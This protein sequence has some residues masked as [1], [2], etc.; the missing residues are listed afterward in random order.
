MYYY[1]RERTHAKFG[2]NARLCEYP[3]NTVTYGLHE[4]KQ[5]RKMYCVLLYLI[6]ALGL[7][8]TAA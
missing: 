3:C 8:V 4:Y 5:L 2:Q 7:K 1:T 6:C